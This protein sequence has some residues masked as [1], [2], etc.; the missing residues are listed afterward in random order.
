MGL[1]CSAGDPE[2]DFELS[3][4]AM[5][6]DARVTDR[7]D[8]MNEAVKTQIRILILGASE[9]GKSTVI[10]QMKILHSGGFTEEERGEEI[11]VIRDNTVASIQQLI[12]GCREL[13]YKLEHKF[14]VLA[15]QIMD[16]KDASSVKDDEISHIENLWKNSRM[17]KRAEEHRSLF[18]LLDSYKYFLDRI[19]NTFKPDY[20]ASDQDIL[21][22]RVTTLGIRETKFLIGETPFIMYDVGGQ[23]GERKKWIHCFDG[24]RAI[25]FVASLS[26]YDQVLQEDAK[27]NRMIESLTLFE[28]I[29]SLVWFREIPIILFLNKNDIFLEKIK[30]SELGRTFPGYYGGFDAE[31]AQQ[32]IVK[33]FLDRNAYPKRRVYTHITTAIDTDEIR[34]V[35]EKTKTV[36]LCSNLQDGDLL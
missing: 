27:K 11:K 30:V 31:E 32:Y 29:L 4:P 1:A 2:D 24:V 21:R 36:I 34:Q 18:Y 20:K 35:W 5:E 25:I 28:G 13:E 33:R 17:I 9:C 19:R 8:A 3:K 26:E 15:D 10:K 16:I 22:A 12:T 14:E 7:L 6:I 23:R